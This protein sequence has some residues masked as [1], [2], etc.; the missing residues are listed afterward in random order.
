M[1]HIG[2]QISIND[3][4]RPADLSG[5]DKPSWIML[6]KLDDAEFP[7][8][9]LSPCG[10][11]LERLPKHQQPKR[12]GGMKTPL[13]RRTPRIVNTIRL[14]AGTPIQTRAQLLPGPRRAHAE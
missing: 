2:E 14:P 5:S 8:L 9:S 1:L 4:Y 3:S 7:V 11:L 12:L 6:N 13:A 10:A